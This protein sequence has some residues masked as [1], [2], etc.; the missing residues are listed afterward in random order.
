[1]FEFF[2]DFILIL[3][4]YFF[5]SCEDLDKRVE[6]IENIISLGNEVQKKSI[7]FLLSFAHFSSPSPSSPSPSLSP[8]SFS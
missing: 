2:I 5:F 4:H 1:M 7:L 8:S 3:F 6:I